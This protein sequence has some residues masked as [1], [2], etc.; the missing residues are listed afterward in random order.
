MDEKAYQA[1]HAASAYFRI[2][3]A[4]VLHLSGEDRST[5][6]QR[7]TTNDVRELQ[8]GKAVVTV[9]TSATARILDVLVLIEED[10]NILVLTLPG[11]GAET[12][13]FLRSRIFF[14]DK[15]EVEEVSSE[16]ALFHLVGPAS[17]R[18]MEGLGLP[19]LE[20]NSNIRVSLAGV[21]TTEVL[22]IGLHPSLGGGY[23]LLMLA[24]AADILEEKLHQAG[25]SP[26][27]EETYRTWQVETGIPSAETELNEEHTPLEA[28]LEELIS[29]NKGCYTGQEIIARQITY[30][31][32]TRRLS[33]LKLQ[34]PTTEGAPILIDGRNVGT[35]TSAVVSPRFGP[36]GLA[37]L[38][39]PH[40]E[41]GAEVWV[42]EGEQPAMVTKLPFSSE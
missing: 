38:R 34:K 8:P 41:P 10:K 22:A 32:V 15:V 27:D 30:D 9:L 12:A 39:R 26:M 31:K 16:Y 20:G 7:Q 40:Y 21:S 5:F 35:V 17:D 37:V 3:N 29:D 4:G 33:G 24:Q 6:M 23:L 13:S 28:R 1:T 25:A 19:E 18:A 11:R 14:M 36:I 42:G 2:R